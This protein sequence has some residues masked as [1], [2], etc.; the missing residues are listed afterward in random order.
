MRPYLIAL[1]RGVV[2]LVIWGLGLGLSYLWLTFVLSQ[3][4]YTQPWGA[5]LGASLVSLFRDFGHAVLRSI[6]NLLIVLVIFLLA[7]LMSASSRSRRRAGRPTTPSSSAPRFRRVR[8]PTSI[9]DRA[10][11]SPI[12]YTPSK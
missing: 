2:R 11:T 3:F 10:Y 12:W 4:P 6:P 5:Q 7:R 8:A 9:Q 1:Q